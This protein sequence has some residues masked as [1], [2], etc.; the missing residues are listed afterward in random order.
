[1]LDGRGGD[2]FAIALVEFLDE[3]RVHFPIQIFGTD[4]NE[5]SIEKARKG[6]YPKSIATEVSSKRLERFFNEVDGNYRVSK[7]IRDVCVFAKQ[8]LTK[9][10]LLADRSYLLS[11]CAY[12][13]RAMTQKRIF[14]IFHYALKPTGY[15]LLGT[16]ESV[17][18]FEDLF[19]LRDKA[20]K[21]FASGLAPVDRAQPFL[22]RL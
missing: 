20:H 5:L 2:S 13:S 14:P 11:Q 8:D 16:S 15:L 7:A 17:G 4:L 6:L 1:V 21:V 10:S 9:T 22:A 18:E 12:L 3:Q 19:T